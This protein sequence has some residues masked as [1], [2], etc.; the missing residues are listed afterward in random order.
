MK[1]PSSKADEKNART[2][3]SFIFAETFDEEFNVSVFAV[4]GLDV[5]LM[6][7]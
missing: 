5:T 7:K 6:D 2:N 4:I 3:P 1:N